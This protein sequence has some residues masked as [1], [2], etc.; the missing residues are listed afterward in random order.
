M[1]CVFSPIAL[2]TDWRGHPHIHTNGPKPLTNPAPKVPNP[3]AQGNAL[4]FIHILRPNG[5]NHPSP[6]HS[7]GIAVPKIH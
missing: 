2:Y 4:I 6:A 5:T 1:P 3:S 7:A